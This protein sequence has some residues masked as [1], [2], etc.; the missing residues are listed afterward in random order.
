MSKTKTDEL[1][2]GAL[3]EVRAVLEAGAAG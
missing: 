2:S 1:F 3:D